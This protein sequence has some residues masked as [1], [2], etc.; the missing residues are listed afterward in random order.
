V[1][2]VNQKERTHTMDSSNRMRNELVGS[3][4]TLT[5]QS[6]KLAGELLDDPNRYVTSDRPQH[7]RPR[8]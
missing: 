3:W 6:E 7:L 4:H 2:I 1:G 8:T 5:G